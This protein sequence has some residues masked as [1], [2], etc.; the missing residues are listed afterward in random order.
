MTAQT[1]Y[2]VGIDI[3][4][5]S[6][7]GVL[8]TTSGRVLAR[9]DRPHDASLPR[10]GWVEHDAESLWW[11]DFCFLA[12]ELARHAEQPPDAICVSGVGPCVLPTDAQ[13]SPLRPAILYGVDTRAVKI[14][15]QIQHDL[16]GADAVLRRCG[17]VISAQAAGPK[18]AWIRANEPEVWQRTR[19]FF[20]A[21][22]YIVYRLTGAYVLD[23]QSACQCVPLY[24][25]LDQSWDADVAESIAPGVELPAL[26]WPADIAG[27]IT[28]AAASLTG[29]PAGTPVAVGTI[30]AWAEAES[31]D[32]RAPGDLMLM[33]GSTMFLIGVTAE[34]ALVPSLW[35]TP[36]NR[37]GQHTLAAG[38]ASSGSITKWF[39][40]LTGDADFTELVSSAARVQPGS[41]G[42]LTLPYFAGERTPI[43]DPNARGVIAGLT[44]SHTRAD[45][46]RSLLEATAF[47]VRHNLDVYAD[48][49]VEPS[50]LVAV[51]G[52]TAEPLWPQIVSDV[53]GRTQEI[54][55]ERV[56]A[57]YGDARFAALSLQAVDPEARWNTAATELTAN[58]GNATLYGDLYQHYLQLRD[59]TAPLQH[60][61]ARYQ[62]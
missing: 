1:R 4:T 21:H 60:A 19:R 40:D 15:E 35:S 18:L 2:V 20:T 53:T 54:P 22:N 57:S 48:A 28:P 61:L 46:Y 42:L 6:S 43:A 26:A 3:G 45:I 17:S 58:P 36:G 8:A 50:R 51:G 27:R 32:V 55:A 37:D 9:Y 41:N 30:D 24:D 23:H 59:A 52:G 12:T 25:R 39:R 49:G 44:L 11:A 5:A 34:P 10:P 29:I 47:G 13:G 7:K 33:Y 31:V 56:G 14:G 38:M 16:G 62:A